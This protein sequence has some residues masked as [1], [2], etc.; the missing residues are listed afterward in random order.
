M[1]P[2]D[3]GARLA[4]IVRAAADAGELPE[5]AI[6]LTASGTWRPAPAEADGGPGTYATALPFALAKLAG[7][8]PRALAARLGAGLD[9]VP[10]ISSARPT[11]AGYLTVTVTGCHLTGL[12]D[13]IIA[14]GPAA[15]RSTALAGSRR[16]PAPRS[17]SFV[18]NDP[19]RP[20]RPGRPALARCRSLWP[21]TARTRFAMR[22]PGPRPGKR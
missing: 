8:E 10:W 15:A 9:G 6:M 12:A 18:R 2:G 14:A 4:G 7:L 3:I 22:W 5:S 16:R 13:R 17:T 21:A 11:G 20:H 1:I 19:A